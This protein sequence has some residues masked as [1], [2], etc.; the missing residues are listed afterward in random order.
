MTIVPDAAR[1]AWDLSG[2]SDLTTY[3]AALVLAGRGVPVWLL[4]AHKKVPAI[5]KWADPQKTVLNDGGSALNDA[6]TD[7]EILE[8]RFHKYGKNCN[9]A[10]PTGFQA[11]GWQLIAGDFDLPPGHKEDSRPTVARLRSEGFEF[12]PT[13]TTITGTGGRHEFYWTT[14]TRKPLSGKDL[15]WTG[16]D[17]QSEGQS[18][19]LPPSK[20]NGGD[21]Y[22]IAD[23]SQQIE[24]LPLWLHELLFPPVEIVVPRAA[25]PLD[26]LS[27][28]SGT[29]VSP[30]EHFS[31]THYWSE[32]L[33]NAG[34]RLMSGDGESPGSKWQRPG[35][36]SGCSAKVIDTGCLAIYSTGVGLD[37]DKAHTKFQVYCYLNNISMSTLASEI[38]LQNKDKQAMR[39]ELKTVTPTAEPTAAPV[40]DLAARRTLGANRAAELDTISAACSIQPAEDLG[41]LLNC[42]DPQDFHD[43]QLGTVWELI[44]AMHSGGVPVTYPNLYQRAP[45]DGTLDKVI[46]LLPELFARDATRGQQDHA[47]LVRTNANQR[48][49]QGLIAEIESTHRT[50]GDL[51][52]LLDRLQNLSADQV[53]TSRVRITNLSEVETDPIEPVY[54]LVENGPALLY[55]GKIHE[56]HGEAGKGKGMTAFAVFL[57]ILRNDPEALVMI[58]DFEEDGNTARS[59]FEDLGATPEE[60]TRVLFVDGEETNNDEAT[61]ELVKEIATRRVTHVLYDTLGRALSLENGKENDADDMKKL[62]TKRIEPLAKK[63]GATVLVLAHTSDKDRDHKDGDSGR[64][65]STITDLFG[66]SLDLTGRGFDEHTG[67]N[68]KLTV[69]KD[70]YGKIGK[71][72]TRAADIEIT[73]KSTLTGEPLRFRFYR[74]AP[75]VDSR[76]HFRPTSIMQ[77]IFDW[78]TDGGEGFEFGITSLRSVGG[79]GHTKDQ[80]TA[81]VQLVHENY[82]LMRTDQKGKIIYSINPSSPRFDGT[83]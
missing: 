31:N 2:I 76:G 73:P 78:A 10:T 24:P 17:I 39:P 12:P 15:G 8:R 56:W 48:R 55:K 36:S 19:I 46:A 83:E 5:P 27:R 49:T 60:I 74:S 54:G 51:S 25:N 68:I 75:S 9:I 28:F 43:Q 63:G 26:R 1:I 30:A 62:F 37:L 65:S 4:S 29:E 32:I 23:E 38:S 13:L 45:K 80:K 69:T 16:I 70:R 22:R 58:A 47:R 11:G 34:W 64:G 57:Q 72:G 21:R 40:E 3:E 53:T 33:E 20:F 52:D 66:V 61:R 82:L 41:A 7:T 71:K 81:T 35:G 18:V 67:G 59:R 79:L 14:E 77:K 44:G 42:C 50:G 6:T